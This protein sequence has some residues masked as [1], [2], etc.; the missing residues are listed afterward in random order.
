MW[1]LELGVFVR[2][3]AVQDLLELAEL[4]D[5]LLLL[6]RLAAA[7]QLAAA[8]KVNAITL[9]TVNMPFRSSSRACILC[10]E[11]QVVLAFVFRTT[12]ETLKEKENM[13]DVIPKD[14]HVV[15]LTCFLVR[16]VKGVV[17][18]SVPLV[19][20]LSFVPVYAK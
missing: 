13:M 19:L 20:V 12:M 16:I 17:L 4:G 11:M 1:N 15:D 14:Y 6:L 18:L 9:L 7:D 3:N 5:A 8:T 10:M 2:L